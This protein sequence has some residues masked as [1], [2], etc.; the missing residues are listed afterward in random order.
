M[1]SHWL[2]RIRNRAR[3]YPTG[4]FNSRA[5]HCQVTTVGK[6]LTWG[7]LKMQDMKMQD[8]KLQDMQRQSRKLAQKR[9]TSESDCV[10]FYAYSC[11]S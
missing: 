5:F 10:A 1:L 3:V 11:I 4:M 2:G 6:L 9:Q 8:M 7:A